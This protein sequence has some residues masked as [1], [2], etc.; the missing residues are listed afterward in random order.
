MSFSLFSQTGWF[1]QNSGT[2]FINMYDVKMINANTAF[3]AGYYPDG[4]GWVYRTT[5]AGI[6]WSVSYQTQNPLN[7]I[8]AVSFS[9]ATT[10][11]AVGGG[12][13]GNGSFIVRTTNGGTSWFTQTTGTNFYH[14]A[15]QMI[16]A[17]TGFIS[18]Y[19]G[20]IFK[21]TDGGSSWT[22]QTSGITRRLYGISFI[23]ANL[24][25]VVGDTGTILRTTNG[26]T[27][28]TTQTAGTNASFYDITMLDANNGMAVG[29]AGTI[30]KTT[31]GGAN[32]LQLISGVTLPLRAL[33]LINLNLCYAV[34]DSGKII[35]T[36]NGGTTWSFQNSTLSQNLRGISFIDTNTGT[37]VGDNGKIIRTTNGGIT[38]IQPI[39]NEIPNKFSLS[40]NYPN[41]FNPETKIV[42]RIAHFGFVT[43]KIFD[44]LGRE[45]AALVNEELKPGSY[46][47]NWNAANYPSGVYFYSL[48]TEGFAETR[49]MV[50]IK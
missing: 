35:R 39:S 23:N 30:L 31:N 29:I 14:L 8:E 18:G 46:E 9:S 34:G 20:T 12:I 17:N 40:Q 13:F 7:G 4:Y 33:S 41:P 43:L 28:W 44:V 26:G 25:T 37:A 3:V 38:F 22:P 36:T 48:T 2:S 5:N 15:V 19:S 6:N 24:G 27:S 21:T 10:G 42:F 49:K 16:D 47:V 32:W 50:L 1:Q 11:T 45:V